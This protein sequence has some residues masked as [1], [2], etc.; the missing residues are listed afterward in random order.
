MMGKRRE[1]KESGKITREGKKMRSAGTRLPT[2][3]MIT[4]LAVRSCR[5]EDSFLLTRLTATSIE[6]TMLWL[7]NERDK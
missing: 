2:V 6:K 7:S 5:L 4:Y 3:T 1:G